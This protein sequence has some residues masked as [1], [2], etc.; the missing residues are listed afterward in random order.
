M[1][2]ATRLS[3][4]E[5]RRQIADLPGWELRDGKLHRDLKFPSFVDDFGFMTR[6]ALVAESRDHHPEWRNVYNRVEIDLSTHD[7]DGISAKDFELAA[8]VNRLY[9]AS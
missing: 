4:D 7:C 1:S 2:R 5:I 3:D 6:L 9:E 8:E